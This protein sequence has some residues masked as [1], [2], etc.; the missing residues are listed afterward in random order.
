LVTVALTGREG[1]S[2]K[3]VACYCICAQADSTPRIQE[4]HIFIGHIL[5][6]VVE[7]DLF[8]K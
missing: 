5:S 6:Q 8:N 2:L 1:K 7:M 3:E 4:A